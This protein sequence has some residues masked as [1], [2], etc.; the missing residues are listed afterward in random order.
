M[1][2]WMEFIVGLAGA[3]AWPAAVMVLA[4]TFRDLLGKL[5]SGEVKRWKAGPA[6]VEIEYWDREA[7]EVKKTI[8]VAVLDHADK[9]KLPEPPPIQLD[10]SPSGAVVAAFARV[11]AALRKIVVS[12]GAIQEDEA[13]SM[14]VRR[15]TNIALDADLI[16]ALTATNIEGLTVLRNLSAHGQAD[17]LDPGRAA[18]FVAMTDGVLYAL[19]NKL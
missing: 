15:L 3:L 18:E 2:G 14:P 1:S 9:A 19:S 10:V 6:G 4:F 12:G 7:D 5:A 13:A 11:E 16:T 8:D 17:D